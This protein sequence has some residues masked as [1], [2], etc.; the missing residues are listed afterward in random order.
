MRYTPAVDDTLVVLGFLSQGRGSLLRDGTSNF[1]C[2]V[3]RIMR[4]LNRQLN[5]QLQIHAEN[6]GSYNVLFRPNQLVEAL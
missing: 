1:K 6:P 2:L 3:D 5:I 4:V